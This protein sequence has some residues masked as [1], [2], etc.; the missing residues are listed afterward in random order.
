MVLSEPNEVRQMARAEASSRIR[1]TIRA[2]MKARRTTYA[3]LAAALDV[4]TSTI[5]RLVNHDDL[6]IARLEQVAD[7]FDLDVYELIAL[8]KDP[9]IRGILLS[10][11]QELYLASH[12]DTARYYWLLL[13]G[14]TPQKIDRRLGLS[15][16]TSKRLVESLVA[17]GLVRRSSKGTLRL[18]HEWPLGFR[19]KGPLYKKYTEPMF[20]G[21]VRHLLDKVGRL[22]PATLA[23]VRPDFSV[24][25]LQFVLARPAYEGLMGEIT[26]LVRRYLKESRR[27]LTVGADDGETVSMMIGID[28][29]DVIFE[30]FQ[31]HNAST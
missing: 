19:F 28:R 16:A 23:S 31:N 11:E 21:F 2:L 29:W 12:S 25:I 18:A 3:D 27:Q 9:T 4:S 14:S 20:A 1:E 17:E 7:F 6:S 13:N 10:E 30:A 8:A 22:D 15:A 26:D 24:R 5:K